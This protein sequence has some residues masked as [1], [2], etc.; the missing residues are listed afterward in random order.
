MSGPAAWWAGPGAALD[1]PSPEKEVTRVLTTAL[2]RA[3][4]VLLALMLV[5]MLAG[6]ALSGPV[7]A[8]YCPQPDVPLCSG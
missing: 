5:A 1:E 8:G 7:Q 6:P 2:S 4:R 3:K